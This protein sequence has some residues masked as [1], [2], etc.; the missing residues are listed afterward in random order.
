MKYGSKYIGYIPAIIFIV[1]VTDLYGAVFELPNDGWYQLQTRDTYITVC[2]SGDNKICDV[3][4]GDYIL[5]DFTHLD[6][7]GNATRKNVTVRDQEA[8]APKSI[9]LHNEVNCSS[10]A[11]TAC[12][13]VC[14]DGYI[15]AGVSCKVSENSGSQF[16][17][18][19][20]QG[21]VG[22]CQSPHSDFPAAITVSCVITNS[23]DM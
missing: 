3:A 11:G 1:T 20:F 23:E 10:T 4:P 9:I 15:V 13:A 7:N 8:S 12:R 18:S 16:L 22:I 17:Y 19:L 21:S 2:Q 6:T 14:P 5:I